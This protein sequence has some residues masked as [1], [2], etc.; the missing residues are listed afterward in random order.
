VEI[1]SSRVLVYPSDFGRTVRFYDEVL[2][3]HRYREFGADGRITGV[4]Y[5]L[6]GGFLEVSSHGRSAFGASDGSVRLWL[7]VRD[8]DAEHARLT[9]MGAVVL[10]PPA[11]MAWG[12]RECWVADPD[13]LR[14]VLVQVPDDHPLR[15]RT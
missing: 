4:V 5:F 15:R 6:G 3:L 9:G 8:V 11:D 10:A 7:Q 14:I 2:G 13:G 12:L 1:L